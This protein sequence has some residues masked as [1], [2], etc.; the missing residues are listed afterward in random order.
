MLSLAGLFSPT[1]REVKEMLYEFE[2]PFIVDNSR[3]SAAFGI[4]A[5][6]LM[7]AVQTTVAWFQA[8]QN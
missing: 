3:F 6:P 4:E 2:E 5:T 7:E 1:V 8:N